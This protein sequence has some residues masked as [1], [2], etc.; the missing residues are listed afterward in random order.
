MAEAYIL[1]VQHRTV[2]GK[3]VRRLRRENQVPAVVY[4]VGGEPVSISCP[5]RPLEILLAKAGATHVITL[6]VEGR[7][8][9]TLVRD[10]QRDPIRLDI[11]HVDFLRIDLNKKLRT[12]VRITFVGNPKLGADLT[13][14][15]YLTQIQVECLPINI[16]DH[17]EVQ[18]GHMAVAGQHVLVK[19]LPKLEG[20]V[21]IHDMSDVVVRLENLS[22]KTSDDPALAAAPGTPEPELSKTKGK[23]EDED[24][25]P[26][27]K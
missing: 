19:D 7:E 20:V 1:D 24:A 12:E 5:R 25:A 23:K 22:G 11:K 16:P 21:Y 9:Y 4:G 2:R 3:Q 8:E 14:A 27:K 6:N 13:L 18:I 17:I 26:A 10:V 15:Q